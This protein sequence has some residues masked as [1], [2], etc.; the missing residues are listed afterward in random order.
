[1]FESR[2]PFLMDG[3]TRRFV[4]DPTRPISINFCSNCWTFLPDEGCICEVCGEKS[5]RFETAGRRE[6]QL[7]G[8]SITGEGYKEY[9]A[10]GYHLFPAYDCAGCLE[11][12]K[13]LKEAWEAQASNG[14]CCR[15][16]DNK[17]ALRCGQCGEPLCAFCA[18]YVVKGIFKKRAVGAPLCFYC[19]RRELHEHARSAVIH[20]KRLEV[21]D[22][23]FRF[24]KTS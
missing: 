11:K 15:H 6:C 7:C 17:A 5:G 13:K 16:R 10:V 1:M 23:Q 14:F 3:E 18:Y 24:T 12:V 19:V 8:K 20:A 2:V 4:L 9:P 22:K 21:S